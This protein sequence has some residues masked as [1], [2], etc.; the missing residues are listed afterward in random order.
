M[1]EGSTVVIINRRVI[2]GE[3]LQESYY[4]RVIT[5]ELLQESYYRRVITEE[6]CGH[7]EKGYWRML[8]EGV[9]RKWVIRV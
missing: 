9:I 1:T 4:R 5:G 2:T 3:L 6:L 7:R 8:F